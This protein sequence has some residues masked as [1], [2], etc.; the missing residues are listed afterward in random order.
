M[1][2]TAF[3]SLGVVLLA[4]CALAWMECGPRRE[5]SDDN[6]AVIYGLVVQQSDGGWYTTEY[7]A[8]IDR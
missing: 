2:K 7:D 8:G 5:D 3:A 6:T 1:R 4:V